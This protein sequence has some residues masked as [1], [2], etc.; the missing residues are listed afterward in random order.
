MKICSVDWCD[1]PVH[2][3]GLCGPHAG[4]FRK[5]GDPLAGGP[6]RDHSHGPTCSFPGCDGPHEARGYC[7][8]HYRRLLAY[9]DP[10]FTK[11]PVGLTPEERFIL[12]SRPTDR[13]IEVA[14][15]L[16]PC[17]GWGRKLTEDG[18]GHFTGGGRRTYAH[19]WAYEHWIGPV[20][21]GLTLDHLCH[22][23]DLSCPGG[24][25]CPHRSCVSPYHLE[26][27]TSAENTLRGRSVGHRAPLQVALPPL[28]PHEGHGSETH[29]PKG[30][31]YDEANTYLLSS[32]RMRSCRTCHRE[33]EAA[34]R[35]VKKESVL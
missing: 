24:P 31:P 26:P 7:H 30:H 6:Y 33:R 9:G 34:R 35:K 29:C 25:T 18:Y 10:A 8:R 15:F 22:T 20:P 12:F 1:K 23:L 16:G 11:I 27:V 13:L 21:L 17:R 5:H 14:P 3:H 32:R 28:L 19:I 4:R 2:A